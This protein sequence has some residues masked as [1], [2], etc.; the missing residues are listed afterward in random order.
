MDNLTKACNFFE[1][2]P[3]PQKYFEYFLELIVDLNL[4]QTR[5]KE[6]IALAKTRWVQSWT[7]YLRLSHFLAQFFFTTSETELD[8]YQQKV[9]ARVPSR[10]AERLKT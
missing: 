10:V 5:W 4:P 2:L 7:K 6:I 8:Y 9:S 3:K 1:N